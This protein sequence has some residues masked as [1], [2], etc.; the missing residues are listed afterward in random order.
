M[1]PGRS[2]KKLLSHM[3]LTAHRVTNPTD[4]STSIN[5]FLHEHRSPLGVSESW[6]EREVSKIANQTPGELVA[7]DTSLPP[8]G[9]RVLSYLEVISEDSTP[10][11]TIRSALDQFRENAGTVPLFN[12]KG[13]V[14]HF[15]L[16]VGLVGQESIESEALINSALGL[17]ES[18]LAS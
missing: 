12:C 18:A 16:N 4:G 6:K 2:E 17:L 8:G 1:N 10:P 7:Q 13:V 5:S 14:I 15:S 11:E 3:Y 9:N